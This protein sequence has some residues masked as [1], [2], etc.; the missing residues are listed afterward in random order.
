MLAHAAQWRLVCR[1]ALQGEP[2]E[3][4][5][6]LLELLEEWALLLKQSLD[7]DNTNVEV[8]PPRDPF[9]VLKHGEAVAEVLAQKLAP[10]RIQDYS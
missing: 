4:W 6:T 5:K 10:R 2:Q 7:Q 1:P 9:Q 3:K 8:S